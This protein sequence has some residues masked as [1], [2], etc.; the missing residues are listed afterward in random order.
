MAISKKITIDEFRDKFDG[1]KTVIHE[2]GGLPRETVQFKLNRD[3]WSCTEVCQHLIQFNRLYIKQMRAATENQSTLPKVEKSTTFN[4]KWSVRKLAGY[5]EPPYSIGIKTVKPMKPQSSNLDPAETIEG[6][7]QIQDELIELL[8]KADRENWNLDKIKGRH[9]LIKLLRLS[10]T[11]FLIIIDAH[12]RRHF[13]QIEQVL[14][15]IP[16]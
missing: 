9:P 5:M 10:L 1:A 11:D 3:T 6:L 7:I 12:Q 8:N 15:R 13:W 4:P 16:E 2:Y 14:K